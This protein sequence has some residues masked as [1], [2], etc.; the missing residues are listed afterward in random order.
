M[1]VRFNCP[2]YTYEFILDAAGIV[3]EEGEEEPE[4]VPQEK[5]VMKGKGSSLS[6][7]SV[8]DLNKLLNEVLDEEDYERAAEIRDEINRRKSE[9]S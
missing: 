2:I 3:L 9:E 8:E 5:P 6:S 1:A 4:E 7:Y